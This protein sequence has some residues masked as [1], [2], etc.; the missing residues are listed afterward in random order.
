MKIRLA[1][2]IFNADT[3]VFLGL[4]NRIPYTKQQTK[5]AKMRLAKCNRRS[6]SYNEFLNF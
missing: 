1:R 6:N 4:S 5:L 3:K 2:K